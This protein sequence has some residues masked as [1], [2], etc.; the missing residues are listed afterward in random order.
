MSNSITLTYSVWVLQ[1]LDMEASDV[2]DAAV[3]KPPKPKH[4]VSLGS[5]KEIE[6]ESLKKTREKVVTMMENTPA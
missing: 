1:A 5:E 3:K 2:F 6:E 4:W